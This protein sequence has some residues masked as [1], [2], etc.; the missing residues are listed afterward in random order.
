M[1]DVHT[2]TGFITDTTTSITLGT[3]PKGAYVKQVHI[4]V[5]EAF[6]TGS[7]RVGIPSNTDAFCTLTAVTTATVKAPTL[8][9]NG[10]YNATSNKVVA[11][12]D[13]SPTSGAAHIIVEYFLLRQKEI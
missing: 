1:S 2:L 4:D 3:L 13:G 8:G 11:D 6:N 10:G 5:T 12:H 7:I 9:S